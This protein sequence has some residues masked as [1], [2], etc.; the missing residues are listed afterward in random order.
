MCVHVC[1]LN[2]KGGSAL[3]VVLFAAPVI[4]GATYVVCE[5]CVDVLCIGRERR[6][7]SRSPSWSP[8]RR[9]GRG[10]GPVTPTVGQIPPQPS[11]LNACVVC[12]CVWWCACVCVVCECMCGV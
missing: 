10:R 6:R 7:R 5:E 9:R 8:P 12:M 1:A 3:C 4:K 11:R 2:F